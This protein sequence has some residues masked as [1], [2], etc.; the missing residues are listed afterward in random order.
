[1]NDNSSH[2][3]ESLDVGARES[4][5]ADAKAKF[6]ALILDKPLSFA[7]TLAE[8]YKYKIRV[9]EIDG[10]RLSV[11]KDYRPY[12]CNVIINNDTIC[13]SSGFH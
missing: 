1:M 6:I 2:A 7:V 11:H 9:V 4:T 5:C 3:E 13:S 12:R 10:D 8:E